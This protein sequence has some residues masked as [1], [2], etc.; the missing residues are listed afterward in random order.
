V[1]KRTSLQYAT[2]DAAFTLLDRL[3]QNCINGSSL[4]ALLHAMN[5]YR[6]IPNFQLHEHNIFFALGKNEHSTIDRDEF[7][8]VYSLI[9]LE[10]EQQVQSLPQPA[11]PFR[12]MIS[13]FWWLQFSDHP[14]YTH[15]IWAATSVSLVL[16][17]LERQVMLLSFPHTLIYDVLFL[18][19][20]VIFWLQMLMANLCFKSHLKKE[21]LEKTPK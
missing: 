2:L 3:Q 5:L 12:K 4:I 21:L 15:F 20:S 1:A 16:A 14:P 7:E 6:D 9:A 10:I 13:K 17:I 11:G 18:K 8:T 19:T